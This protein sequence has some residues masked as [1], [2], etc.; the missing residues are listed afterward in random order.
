M[1]RHSDKRPNSSILVTVY[2]ELVRYVEAFVEG[3]L[4]LLIIIGN[5]GLSKS[6]IV[7]RAVGESVCWIEG[8]ATPF[9]MYC[10]LWQ[11]RHQPTV[12]DDVDGLYTN[13]AGV[14]LL[15][16][17][18]QTDRVKHIAWHSDAPTLAREGIPREFETTSRVVIIANEWRTLNKNVSAIED[19]GHVLFFDPTAEEV[20]RQT[21]TWFK[22]DDEV[23]GFIGQH[24]HLISE[25]SM[26]HYVLASEQKRAGLDWRGGL[27]KRW[28]SG[29]T[30][31]VARLLADGRYKTEEERV[32]AFQRLTGHARSTYFYQKK[33]LTR[34]RYSDSHNGDG[35]L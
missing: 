9:R 26:R 24:L 31:D 35:H 15:K 18:C 28:L 21:A 16:G 2:E 25:P 33:K 12:I 4:G 30:L 8:N 10:A 32:E 34:G 6:Q 27:L 5:P 23:F 7:R 20:H 3:H 17:L 13:H 22:D 19:R 14:R 1:P 29:S 11:H